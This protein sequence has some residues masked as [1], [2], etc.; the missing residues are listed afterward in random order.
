MRVP[1]RKCFSAFRPKPAHQYGL[2]QETKNDSLMGICDFQTSWMKYGSYVPFVPKRRSQSGYRIGTVSGCLA[3]LA[4]MPGS[5]QQRPSMAWISFFP[6]MLISMRSCGCKC[7]SGN[8]C[9]RRSTDRIC[10]IWSS[11]LPLTSGRAGTGHISRYWKNCPNSITPQKT[12]MVCWRSSRNFVRNN[13]CFKAL[14]EKGDHLLRITPMRALY[15]FAECQD[16]FFLSIFPSR[17]S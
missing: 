13:D 8:I 6:H 9:S 16:I 12:G 5:F 15:L 11:I 1:I 17:C 10:H 4:D 3:S 14:S 7:L 2:C